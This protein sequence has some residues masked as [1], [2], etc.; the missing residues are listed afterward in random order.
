[1]SRESIEATVADLGFDA[2]IA[3]ILVAKTTDTKSGGS[4]TRAAAGF[5]R[6]PIG[7]GLRVR[8]VLRAYGVPVITRLHDLAVDRR[9]D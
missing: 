4:A 1:L 3:T 8:R 2:V 5:T 6:R 7:L 9:S